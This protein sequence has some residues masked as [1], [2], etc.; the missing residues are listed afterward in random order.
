MR[1]FQPTHS[2]HLCGSFGCCLRAS[3]YF[4]LWPSCSA[5]VRA[6]CLVLGSP[7]LALSFG[8]GAVTEILHALLC[9]LALSPARHDL[10]GKKWV[11]QLSINGRRVTLFR[12]QTTQLCGAL[13]QG[14]HAAMHLCLATVQRR[15]SGRAVSGSRRSRETLRAWS[16]W[17]RM[18]LSTWLTAPPGPRQGT[19]VAPGVQ[20]RR[21]RIG[22]VRRQPTRPAA[23]TNVLSS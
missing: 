14:A 21:V 5:C 2:L 18:P 20:R 10:P 19:E 13:Q 9:G 7:Y 22:A 1:C 15:L 4:A 17:V 23:A 8:G 11:V 6:R 3:A 12:I 16:A